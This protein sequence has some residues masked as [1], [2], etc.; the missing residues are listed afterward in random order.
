MDSSKL[1]RM[2]FHIRIKPKW[3]RFLYKLSLKKSKLF[4]N[5]TYNIAVDIWIEQRID[6]LLC[7]PSWTGE[8]K[9]ICIFFSYIGHAYQLFSAIQFYLFFSKIAVVT[10]HMSTYFFIDTDDVQNRKS[11][12]N[13]SI[14]KLKHTLQVCIFVLWKKKKK[15]KLRQIQR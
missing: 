7:T 2:M 13:W 12:I 4:S 9:R 10:Q 5:K 14:N 6:I 3:T 8:L 15:K 1:W 11:S